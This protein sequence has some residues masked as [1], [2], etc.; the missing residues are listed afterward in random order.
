MEAALDAFRAGF[1]DFLIYTALAA[2][3]LLISSV[4]YVLL[5]PWKELTLL[6]GGNSSAG[7]A[8]AGAIVGLAIPLTAVL[9]SSRSVIDFLLW[10]VVALLLQLVAYR[11]TDAILRDLPR[12]IENDDAGAAIVLLAVKLS[13][14]MILAAGL[15]DPNAHL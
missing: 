15:W 11:L 14:A 10:S 1:P 12:R 2:I 5:T 4:V 13:T 7:L 9:A 6:R 3:L 8:L